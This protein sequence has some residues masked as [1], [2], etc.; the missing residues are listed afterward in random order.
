[1]QTSIEVDKLLGHV[2]NLYNTTFWALVSRGGLK[3][4]EAEE[5][6]KVCVG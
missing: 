4:T 3:P 1:M 6:L 5:Q 2:N